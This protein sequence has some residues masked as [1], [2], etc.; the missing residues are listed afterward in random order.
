MANVVKINVGN[1]NLIQCQIVEVY[2][3]YGIL[4]TGLNNRS[5]IRSTMYYFGSWDKGLESLR[6]CSENEVFGLRATLE[7][8]GGSCESYKYL[9]RNYLISLSTIKCRKVINIETHSYP[10]HRYNDS[11]HIP[12]KALPQPTAPH[13]PTQR[14]TGWLIKEEAMG[15][16][17]ALGLDSIIADIRRLSTAVVDSKFF[18]PEINGASMMDIAIVVTTSFPQFTS[19]YI[20]KYTIE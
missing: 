5:A 19:D 2:A 20:T 15:K 13:Q 8:N 17:V 18:I 4:F 1:G 3:D 12:L 11:Y 14:G 9:G 10:P 16:L 6:G 7:P